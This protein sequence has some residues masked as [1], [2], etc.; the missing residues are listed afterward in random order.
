MVL[1][2]RSV[3][4]LL[5]LNI[6][7]L[8]GNC[9]GGDPFVQYLLKVS[10]ITASPLGTPQQVIA[11][12]GKFPGPVINVTTN[13]NL[14]IN[15][16]NGLDEDLLMTWSGIQMRKN[17][18]Q[19]GVKDQIGSFF[20]FPSLNLQRASGGFG[21]FIVNNRDIIPIPFAAPDADIV[22]MIGDWYTRNHSALRADLDA[23]KDLGM[24]D[25][26]LINGKGP[27]PY[28]STLVPSG[29]EYETINVD[30]GNGPPVTINEKLRATVNG[31]SFVNLTTPIR[32][33]DQYNQKGVYKLDFPNTPLPESPKMDRSVIN[34]TY[35]GF[36]EIVFQN[37][38][39]VMQSYHL[40]GY[41]FFV[42]GMDY[43]NWTEDS[44][45]T[46]NKWDAISRS[47][48]QVY[49]GA[50]TAVY[51]SLDNP[52]A[53]NLRAENLDRCDDKP[54]EEDKAAASIVGGRPEIFFTLLGLLSFLMLITR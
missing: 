21:P 2:W 35:K 18:W 23:G 39:T 20:Y 54:Y 48:V 30:P 44:R 10:Y 45:G 42:V 24:P 33:A 14:E 4:L 31:I 12:N 26:V 25:G 34:A 1:F 46:Y 13:Y 27:Y 28:N 29:I 6:A 41:S 37:N 22:I 17:S 32:L 7:L 9:F 43:G 40:D 15:V 38:D 51:V 8:F 11:I 16:A 19:D 50:W 53:W 49:P 52:G 3:L 5:G 47:T 36:I